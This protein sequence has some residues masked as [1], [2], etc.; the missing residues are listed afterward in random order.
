MKLYNYTI[1]QPRER[2]L[3]TLDP[4]AGHIVSITGIT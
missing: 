1:L 3:F 2:S 4:S